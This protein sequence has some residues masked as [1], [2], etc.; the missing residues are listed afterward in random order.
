MVILNVN[1]KINIMIKKLIKDINLAIKQR[2][3]LKFF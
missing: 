3:H 1:I 2:H